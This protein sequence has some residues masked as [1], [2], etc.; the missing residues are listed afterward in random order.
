MINLCSAASKHLVELE[1]CMAAS[2]GR[3]VT[4]TGGCGGM[5]L[6][7]LYPPLSLTASNEIAVHH[8][9]LLSTDT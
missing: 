1:V 3:G 2:R 9:T 5:L 6:S 8:H 7:L 4:D